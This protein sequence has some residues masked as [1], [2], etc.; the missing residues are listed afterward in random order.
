MK[1]ILVLLSSY[2]GEKYIKCQLDSILSQ[3]NVEVEILVRD[4]GST[5]KTLDI[6]KKYQLEGKLTYYTG[7]N[8]KPAQSFMDLIDR[9]PEADYYALSDQDDF[10]QPQKLSRAISKLKT[11]SRHPGPA[12]YYGKTTPTDA[13]LN[14]L[15]IT[16]KESETFCTLSQAI[17]WNSA[18]GCTFVFNKELLKILRQY[19]PKILVM[20]DAWIYQLCMAL[21]YPVYRDTESFIYYRQ[22]STNVMGSHTNFRKKWKQRICNATINKCKRSQTIQELITGY[23]HL[24]PS[25][26]LIICKRIANYK[27]TWKDKWNLLKDTSIRTGNKHIDRMFILKILLGIF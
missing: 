15:L 17:I 13:Q 21:K 27:N 8:L 19:H 5:D 24:I 16:P 4:D 9:A 3:Q 7:K 12:L 10:W 23:G 11:I 22:H 1:K 26:N 14:P 6:L 18:A 2:N 20:H 25:E